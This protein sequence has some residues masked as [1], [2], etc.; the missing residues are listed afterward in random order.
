[1]LGR[2]TCD[3]AV[4]GALAVP[5]GTPVPRLDSIAS[6]KSF[7]DS[8]LGRTV[9]AEAPPLPRLAPLDFWNVWRPAQYANGRVARSASAAA[10]ASAEAAAAIRRGARTAMSSHCSICTHARTRVQ[11]HAGVAACR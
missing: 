8:A 10:P 4:E 1:M 2:S 11:M 5:V 7:S 9:P 3:M 6:E